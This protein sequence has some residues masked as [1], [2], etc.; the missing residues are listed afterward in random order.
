MPW[1]NLSQL[2]PQ[3][4]QAIYAYLH[5]RPA[6]YKSVETH[7]GWDPQPVKRASLSEDN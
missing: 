5:S 6:V 4:L 1:L 7:P 3:D 2:P